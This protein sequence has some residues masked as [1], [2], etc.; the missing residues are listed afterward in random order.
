MSD[1]RMAIAEVSFEYLAKLLELPHGCKIDAIFVDGR[2]PWVLQIRLV[3]AGWQ[4]PEGS[5]VPRII[6]LVRMERVFG[7]RP[8]II[9]DLPQ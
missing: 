6:G 7:L 4:T 5:E 8:E 2:R 9:W 3:G 1:K